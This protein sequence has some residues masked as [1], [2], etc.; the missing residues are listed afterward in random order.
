MFLKNKRRCG[1]PASN[2]SYFVLITTTTTFVLFCFVL[3]FF[4]PDKIKAAFILCALASFHIK[5]ALVECLAINVSKMH[6]IGVRP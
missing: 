6:C 3:F 4:G 1:G 5:C 2:N